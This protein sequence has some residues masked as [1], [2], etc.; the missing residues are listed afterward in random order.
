MNMVNAGIEYKAAKVHFILI[1]AGEPS[2]LGGRIT[3][4][5]QFYFRL[6]F[7]CEFLSIRN[8]KLI[9]TKCAILVFSMDFYVYGYCF[10]SF[11]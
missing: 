1:I 3:G 2:Y 6:A 8:S 7:W 9:S 11:F 5:N 4:I 10:F